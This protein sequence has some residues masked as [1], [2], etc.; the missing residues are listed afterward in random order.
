LRSTIGGL[1]FG[2]CAALRRSSVDLLRGRVEVAET[3]VDVN[4]A[5][6]FG[7]PKTSKGRR[8]VP[9]PRG[10]LGEL[11]AHVAAYVEPQADALLFTSTTRTPL[12]RS[13]F[14]RN[15]WQP[16]VRM[17]G[18]EP[19]SFHELRHVRRAGDRRRRRRQAGLGAGGSQLGGVHA[20]PL[21]PPVRGWRRSGD[22][23]SRRGVH[24]RA[25]GR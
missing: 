18:L 16:A 8:T 6:S 20:R 15:W 11:E 2:E 4:G 14:R 13:G 3:L 21:R 9:L 10:V 17:V 1:R 22:G 12:R 5:L 19:L 23:P 25:A 7:P 24:K